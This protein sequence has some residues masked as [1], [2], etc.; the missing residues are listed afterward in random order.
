MS[1]NVYLNFDGNCREA[2]M[3]YSDVFNVEMPEMMAFGDMP[4]DPN[5]P[6]PEEAKDRIMHARMDVFGGAIMF[7][8]T[9]PGMP[10]VEGNNVILIVSLPD[11]DAVKAFFNL[12]KEDGKVEMELQETFWSKCY[13]SL[14]DKFGICWQFNYE[15]EQV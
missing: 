10:F 6:M 8:D 9:F 5:Y 14:V 13:G 1:M 7:S 12:L 3:F 15:E 11:M 2:V 4:A